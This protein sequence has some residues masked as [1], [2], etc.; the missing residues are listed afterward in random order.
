MERRVAK[1]VLSALKYFMLLVIMAGSFSITLRNLN[2]YRLEKVAH[3]LPAGMFSVA[4]LDANLG[5][6]SLHVGVGS[7][8][9]SGG[10]IMK[11]G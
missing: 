6:S 9:D 2:R 10:M 1:Q 8:I 4:S 7:T 3:V 11:L 5:E